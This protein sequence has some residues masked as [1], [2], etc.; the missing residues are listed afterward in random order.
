MG[1]KSGEHYIARIDE[2]NPNVWLAGEKLAVKPSQHP[3][4]RGLMRTQAALYDMQGSDEHRDKLT[5]WDPELDQPVGLSYLQPKT[6]RDLA[7]RRGMMQTWAERHHGFLGRSPDY[8]NTA[9]MAF[10]VSAPLLA[11]EYPEYADNVKRYYKYCRE[12]DITLSHAFIQP[13]SARMTSFLQSLEPP[14][15]AHVVE[16]TTDGIIVSGAFYMTT[17]GVTAEE[18]IV[19]PTPLPH[20]SATD[21][22]YAFVFAVPNNLE[23]MTFVCRENWANADSAYDYPLS[24]AMDEMDT[25]VLFDHVKIPADRVFLYGDSFMVDRWMRECRFHPHAS[26][27]ILCRVVAKTEFI[28]GLLEC[29]IETMGLSTYSHVTEKSAEVMAMTETLRSMLLASEATAAKDRFGSMLPNPDILYSAN[30][31]YPRLYPRLVEILQ[32]IGAGG[33]IMIPGEKDFESAKGSELEK[34]LRSGSLDAKRKTAL[35]R[36][37]W[38]IGASSFGGRQTLYE[39]FFFGDANRVASRAVEN[40]SLRRKHMERVAEFLNIDSASIFQKG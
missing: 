35:L 16:R 7:R 11:K 32:L 5:Y 33:L 22:P 25:L 2:A 31:L 19:F 4:F 29:I 23:G 14:A 8:M 21:N 15:A 13:P 24:S 38:E 39:R 18:I 10:S 1:I 12:N 26:H 17:Q 30:F 37:A 9:L 28:G 40:Y 3:A 36:L 6:K 20:L 27:Q 34:Y